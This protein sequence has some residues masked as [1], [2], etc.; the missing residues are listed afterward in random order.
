MVARYPRFDSFLVNP[1]AAA[2][3]EFIMALSAGVRSLLSQYNFKEPGDISI[4]TYCQSAFDTASA[5]C[6][7]IKSLG[8]KY[9]GKIEILSPYSKDTPP[10][11]CA[12]SPVSEEA[13]VYLKIVGKVDLGREKEKTGQSLEEAKAKVEKSRKIMAGEGW[14]KVKKETREKE[15]KNLRDAEAEVRRF[16]EVGRDLERLQLE[17]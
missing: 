8:G 10:A 9:V 2:D 13:A 7:S 4:Q 12:V 15:E 11:G 6:A 3:Y 16:E 1:S 5:E 17:V 14:G